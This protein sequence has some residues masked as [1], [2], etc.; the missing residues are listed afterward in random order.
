M[1]VTG[2][3]MAVLSF[4]WP[5]SWYYK[6]SLV[7]IHQQISH[8]KRWFNNLKNGWKSQLGLTICCH[9]VLLSLTK[10]NKCKTRTHLFMQHLLPERM[11]MSFWVFFIFSVRTC[12][13]IYT[14]YGSGFRCHPLPA[15]F[16]WK[17]ARFAAWNCRL[18]YLAVLF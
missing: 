7:L 10:L 12:V 17:A 1:Q 3:K 9:S 15:I 13:A 6:E 16:S 2:L 5:C 11:I 14:F 8:F 18:M 4:I